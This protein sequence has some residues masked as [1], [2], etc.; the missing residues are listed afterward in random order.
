MVC[1]HVHKADTVQAWKHAQHHVWPLMV[2]V[3]L[4]LLD[5]SSS[6][7]CLGYLH[8][9]IQSTVRLRSLIYVTGLTRANQSQ[10]NEHASGA[11]FLDHISLGAAVPTRPCI[12]FQRIDVALHSVRLH[13]PL[14]I[15]TDC[16][17]LPG[18]W[19]LFCSWFEPW[20]P[21][22]ELGRSRAAT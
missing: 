5:D 7:F 1:L 6:S 12:A 18:S 2:Q 21:M 9:L 15:T 20:Y 11:C 3:S 19:F 4:L 10:A 14:D 13:A 22:S 17:L 8:R 16:T